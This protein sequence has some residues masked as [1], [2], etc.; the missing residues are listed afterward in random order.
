MK[1]Y[2][3]QVLPQVATMILQPP[4]LRLGMGSMA[5]CVTKQHRICL[6][7]GLFKK[8][9]EKVHDFYLSIFLGPY[10][11]KCMSIHIYVYI[12]KH[13]ISYIVVYSFHPKICYFPRMKYEGIHQIAT[14]LHKWEYDNVGRPRQRELRFLQP[15]HTILRCRRAMLDSFGL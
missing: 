11:L 13:Q 5:G 15:R 12:Y 7:Y 10:T 2:F 4:E 6:T 3:N 9:V 8:N 1:P 14:G